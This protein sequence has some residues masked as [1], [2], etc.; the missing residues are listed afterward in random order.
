[1]KPLSV[2]LSLLAVLAVGAGSAHAAAPPPPRTMA[3]RIESILARPAYRHARWGLLVVNTTTG[4]TIYER[5][6]EQLFAPASVTKLFTCA[7]AMIELG[8]GHRFETPVYRRGKP[9][10]GKLAGDLIL[11]AKGDLT[12][13]GRTDRSGKMAFTNDDHIYSSPTGTGTALTDTDPLAGLAELARQVKSAG[14]R[15]IS[16][17]VLID[18]RLFDRSSG[19]G[20][21][22]GI[23]T[24]IVV[25][26][27]LVDVIVKP[28]DKP[29]APATWQLRPE[30]TFVQ[31]DVQVE[32]VEKQK[33]PR[34]VASNLGQRRY[35]VRGQIPVGQRPVVRICA[36]DD[37]AG[38]ARAL[39]IESLRKAGIDV[40]ASVLRTPTA[41]LPSAEDYNK[42]TRVALFRSPPLSEALKVTLKV[43]HNLYAS[44]LPLLLAVK[45][46]K[47]TQPEGMRVEGAVLAKLGVAINGLSLES[48]AGGGNGDK[49]SP[50]ATVQLLRAMR[51]RDDWPIFESCLPILGVDGTLAG[52]GKNSPARGKV[53]GKTGT[54]T[55][56]NHLLGRPFLRAKTLA[57][58][59]RTA[60]GDNLLFAIFVNDVVPPPGV[61]SVREGKVIGQLCEIIQQHAR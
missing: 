25:N 12:L 11:V 1:M 3:Q 31:V 57:G 21:G 15:A 54:Y 4:K 5:N 40:K 55:D 44:T 19:S 50:R 27:N 51:Q 6:A 14:I 39:F 13:G 28:G 9:A 47:R 17:D 34:V 61:T 20:S 48:G 53:L 35:T 59:M 7:A 32:T 38:F 16:G 8:P 29:G 60:R 33:P 56:R 18:D 41:E 24:P 45:H 42:L 2:R 37:P 58:T 26:D 49:V 36:V 30:T 10:D 43:S 22:P 52:V 46:H 23:V